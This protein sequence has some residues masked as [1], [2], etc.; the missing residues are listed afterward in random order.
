MSGSLGPRPHPYT[1]PRV[2][3]GS[4]NE[5]RC[6]AVTFLLSSQSTLRRARAWKKGNESHFVV[7]RNTWSCDVIIMMSYTKYSTEC[8]Q[9]HV[10][11]HRM[12]F[13]Q[14][15]VVHNSKSEAER[16]STVI[17]QT[18]L[19]VWNTAMPLF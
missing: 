2:G 16:Y 14:F 10:A 17:L 19:E 15:L 4:G 1:G 9:L 12:D 13:F 5:T 8:H 7:S 3:V 18:K 6:L 11:L